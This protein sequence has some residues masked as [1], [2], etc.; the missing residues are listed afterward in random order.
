MLVVSIIRS[1]GAS[2]QTP[3]V[4]SVI[5]QLVPE[6]HLMRYNGIY[7]TVQS[8]V[9]FAAPTVAGAIL[10]IG[11]FRATLFIDILTAF[12]VIGLLSCI[13]LP[14]Q[15]VSNKNVSVLSEI[16]SGFRYLFSDEIIGKIIIVY[17]MYILLC[18]PAGFMAALLVSRV[19]GDTYWYL[20]ATTTIIQENAESTM[21]GIALV[22]VTVYSQVKFK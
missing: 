9:Q 5:P 3:A 18:V 6:E 15:K 8:I 13:L 22:L 7:A 1:I 2:I 17:G 4:N 16:K 20:T 19:Y 14:K 12:I 10:S 21:R 11:T